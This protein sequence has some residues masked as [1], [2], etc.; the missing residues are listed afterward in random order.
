MGI[1]A[2][3]DFAGLTVTVRHVSGMLLP[4]G[5]VVPQRRVTETLYVLFLLD[6]FGWCV[7]RVVS[8][9]HREDG[10]GKRLWWVEMGVHSR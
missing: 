3:V 6:D 1:C 5:D 8:Q 10:R 2:S 7:R 9:C 4:L